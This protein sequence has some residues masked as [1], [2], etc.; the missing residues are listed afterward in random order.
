METI[1]F[2]DYRWKKFKGEEG[3]D[4]YVAEF[5][6]DEEHVLGQYV[7][8][9]S[10]DI[11]IDGVA[12]FYLPNETL[13]DEEVLSED[14]LAFK[15]RKYIF[16]N[17]E[18]KG[19]LEGLWGAASESNNRGLAAGPREERNKTRDWVTN[20]QSEVLNWYAK[21]QPMSA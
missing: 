15:F 6:L 7:D 17:E 10:Y 12:D 1:V 2:G 3:Q 14:R 5:K 16:T 20:Y 19:A 4:V 11:L 9:T 18:Q 21:G 13:S 8:D